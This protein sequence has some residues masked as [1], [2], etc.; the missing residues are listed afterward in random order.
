MNLKKTNEKGIELIVV[1]IIIVFIMALVLF[2]VLRFHV[3]KTNNKSNSSII[4]KEA[5][6]NRIVYKNETNM[7]NNINNITLNNNTII[8][9][10]IISNNIIENKVTGA[11]ETVNNVV[12][13]NESVGNNTISEPENP[14]VSDPPVDNNNTL[15]PIKLNVKEKETIDGGELLNINDYKIVI[16]NE[17]V[18]IGYE[19]IQREDVIR[20]K[21]K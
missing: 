12:G 21:S 9:N 1:A 18:Q 4:N 13:I 6:N 11:N 15:S 20:N 10:N 14:I 19:L 7:T 16:P 8:N 3:M 5:S 2:F 17:L